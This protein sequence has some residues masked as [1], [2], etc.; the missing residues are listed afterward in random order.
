MKTDRRKFIKKTAG[1]TV[2]SALSPL[3]GMGKSSLLSSPNPDNGHVF[4]T[5][6]YLQNPTSN[7]MTIMWIVNMPSYSYVEYGIN[8]KME[9]TAREVEDGLVVAYNR[10]NQ[11]KL[12]ELKPETTYYYRVVSKEIVKFDP[13]DLVYGETIKSDIYSFKTPSATADH[14]S[15][16]VMNDIHDRPHTIPHL[17]NLYRNTRSDFVFYNGDVFDHQEDEEQIIEHLLAPSCNTFATETPFLF[18]RGNHETRGKYAR[19]LQ[20]YFSNPG[21]G[22]YYDY[23]WGSVHF[24]V[25]DTGED[26]NDDH[27]EYGDIV[28]FDPYRVEQLEWFKEVSKTKAFKTAKFRVVLMHIPIYYSGNWHGTTHLRA[29]FASEFNKTGIDICISGHTHKYGIHK[30]VKGKH[31]YPIIIGGGPIEGNRTIISVKAN[32]SSLSLNMVRDDGTEVGSVEI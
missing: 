23:R 10:I 4:L 29:L 28:N 2:L 31:N 19:K 7:S 20:Y 27:E 8:S 30:P 21:G 22:Q 32:S 24:T 12:N 14:V 26:K 16:L 17:M 5:K 11:V 18:L 15:F 13:Y 9:H 1:I 3:M 6:P 25:L